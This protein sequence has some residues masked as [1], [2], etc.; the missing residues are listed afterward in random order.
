MS[1]YAEY[2]ALPRAIYSV[3]FAQIIN[4]CGDFVIPFLS[5][6]LVKRYGLSF[7]TS[8]LIV[9]MVFLAMSP[10][11]M[12]G[13]KLADRYGRKNIYLIFQSAA[14]CC[15]F[16]AAF[17]SHLWVLVALIGMSAFFNGGVRP[18]MQAIIIDVLPPQ[19]RTL[20]FT[21]SY[22][23]VNIGAAVGML[24]AGYLFNNHTKALFIGDALSSF[25]AVLLMAFS[26]RETL[27][28][29]SG[30][31]ASGESSESG[32]TWTVVAKRPELIFFL[33]ICVLFS[34]A[35]SQLQFSMPIT[36]DKV[37]GSDGASIFGRLSSFNCIIVL[38]FTLHLGK[39]SHSRNILDVI[40]MAA[41]LFGVG[42]G[43]IYFIKNMPMFYLSTL[44]F[45]M[46]EILYI[47]NYNT[48][49]ANHT[50]ANFRA[51]IGGITTITW[52]MGSILGTF[53]IGRFMDRF[54]TRAVWGLAFFCM[55]LAALGSW[56]LKFYER[57]V[58][59]KESPV[60][61]ETGDSVS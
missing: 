10:G 30:G 4:R 2:R 11:A 14:G 23:G 49:I 47:S 15:L 61:E 19:S 44:V 1:F 18:A 32:N 38:F 7:Q 58:D 56:L 24:M 22:L 13:G 3:F 42:L 55:M 53:F 12:L 43:M 16:A 37:F 51:R 17:V 9:M 45:T 29:E 36:L 52:G 48:Y 46:G 21:L 20:G 60:M 57:R 41:V 35:Y 5:L 26:I 33:M 40:T 28:A 8:G 25:L 54:G 31:V 50:P 39:W 6:L 34:M 27:P 59:G